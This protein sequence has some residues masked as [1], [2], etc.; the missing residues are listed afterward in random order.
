MLSHV[1]P[2]GEALITSGA[3]VVFSPGMLRCVAYRM[4]GCSENGQAVVL[5][6]EWAWMSFPLRQSRIRSAGRS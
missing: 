3:E 1:V 2:A 5:L 6:R 4:A